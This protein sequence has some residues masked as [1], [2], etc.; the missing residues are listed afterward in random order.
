MMATILSK[1][2]EGKSPFENGVGGIFH[3]FWETIT[4]DIQ[5]EFVKT[6]KEEGAGRA[7]EM[8]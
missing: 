1:D 7:L 8:I 6:V 3:T 5:E 2:Y 4:F